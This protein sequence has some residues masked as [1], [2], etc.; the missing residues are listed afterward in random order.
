M[1]C[2]W[3]LGRFQK[4]LYFNYS[5][6]STPIN[7][8]TTR[9]KMRT[10]RWGPETQRNG[11]F[12]RCIN[13]RKRWS[14]EPQSEYGDLLGCERVTGAKATRSGCDN[15]IDKFENIIESPALWQMKQAFLGVNTLRW[16]LLL[17]ITTLND[18]DSGSAAATDIDVAVQLITV[19]SLMTF[20]L[21]G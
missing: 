12:I 3:C 19:S 6:P 7:K 18:V 14:E 16:A 13:S 1:W 20:K 21:K 10:T 8:T 4:S 11:W 15:S 5:T 9:D 17:M 2:P